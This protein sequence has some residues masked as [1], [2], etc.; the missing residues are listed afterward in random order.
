MVSG[1]SYSW[2]HLNSLKLNSN[3]GMETTGGSEAQ[4][5]AKANDWSPVWYSVPA[6]VRF[7]MQY[8][9]VTR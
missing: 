3:P 5:E 8:R 2:I 6:N 1:L 4:M 9:G 7:V